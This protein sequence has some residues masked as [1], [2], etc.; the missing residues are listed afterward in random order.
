MITRAR[1]LRSRRINR[2]VA[3]GLA[4]LTLALAACGGESDDGAGAGAS[5]DGGTATLRIGDLESL[6]G[7]GASVGVPQ[8]NAMKLAA[9]RINREGGI[10]IGGK[11]YKIE[12]VTEDDKSDPTAGV[13]AVQ[14]LINSERVNYMVGST[15]SAVTAAYVPI[16]KNRDDFISIVVSAALEGITE[17]PQIYRPRV[18]NAQYTDATVK[19]LADQGDVKTIALLT[20]K[21]HAG[22]V[23]ETPRLKQMLKEQ[24]I[25]TVADESYKLGDTQFGGQLSAMLRRKPDVLNIRGYPADVSRAIKQAREQ[26]FDGPIITNSGTT[27]TEVKDAQ[28]ASAMKNVTDIFMPLPE[29]QIALDLNTEASKRFLDDYRATFGSEPSGT[30][31]SAYDGLRILAAALARVSDPSDV[32]GVRKALDELTVDDVPGLITPF[33]AQ[34]GGRLFKERQSYFSVVAREWATEKGDWEPKQAI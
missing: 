31:A 19:F 22:F 30:S 33:K 6:T 24:G 21:E 26:G 18:T 9:E 4:A 28:A 25:E 29:D 11:T 14:K 27:A 32:A 23:A 5:G 7:G 8:A 17:H 16:V 15:S 12:L 2:L 10:K 1:R 13:T 20:D 34:D 3:V